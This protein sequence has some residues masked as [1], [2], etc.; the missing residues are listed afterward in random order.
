MIYHGCDFKG[1][2]GDDSQ[3]NT[4]RHFSDVKV[5][6]Y[7]VVNVVTIQPDHTI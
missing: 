1:Y 5:M 7:D 4:K 6:L 3:K 2:V